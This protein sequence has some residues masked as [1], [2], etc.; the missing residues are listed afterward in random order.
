MES[1]QL[2]S[3]DGRRVGVWRFGCRGGWPLVWHHGGLS[4]GL[5]ATVV[6]VAAQ[7][8]SADIISIDRP[9]IGRSDHWPISPIAQW[10]QTVEKVADVLDLGEFAVAGWSGGGPYALACAGAMPQRVRAAATIAGM[11]PLLCMKDVFGLGMWADRLL[12]PAAR[13]SPWV[14][15][16]LVWLARYV[17]DRYL[18]RWWRKIRDKVGM[19]HRLHDLRHFYASGLIAAGCDVVTVQ[20]ALGHSSASVTLDKYSPLVAGPNDRTRNAR[21]WASS[22]RHSDLLR[23]HGGRRAS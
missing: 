8:C 18:M 5:D 9:G 4:C 10:T 6:D 14:A 3:V 23:T 1:V 20:R 21:Q 19:E 11:A 22:N 16:A 7:R 12:I 15:A 17:P 13:W 2:V